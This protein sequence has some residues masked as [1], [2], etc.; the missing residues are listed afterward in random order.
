MHTS[1][2][3][4]ATV[5]IVSNVGTLASPLDREAGTID[6]ALLSIQPG[7][8]QQ[9][10][11]SQQTGVQAGNSDYIRKAEDN[12]RNQANAWLFAQSIDEL[13]VMLDKYMKHHD[14]RMQKWQRTVSSRRVKDE[15]TCTDTTRSPGM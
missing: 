8:D 13:E 12:G 15:W 2:L 5:L 11:S 4:S 1:I 9:S 3:L 10:S 7:S 14:G 6:P